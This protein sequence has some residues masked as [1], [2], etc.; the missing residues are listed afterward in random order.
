MGEPNNLLQK[1]FS[2]NERFADL[3]NAYVGSNILAASDLAEKDSQL[4][5]KPNRARQQKSLNLHRDM[6]R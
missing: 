1:Y 3:V 2:D 5:T 4:T 6:I